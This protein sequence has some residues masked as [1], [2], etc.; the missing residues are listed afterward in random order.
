LEALEDRC[1]PAHWAVT[2]PADNINQPGTLRWA[3]AQATNG[4]TID[5]QTT[6]PI[7]LAY[8]EL[9]LA[10]DVTIDF[11]PSSPANQATV[12]GGNLSRVFEVAPTA[13]VN[14]DNLN[15]INGAGWAGNPSG[16]FNADGHGGAILNQGTLAL[17]SCTLAHNVRLRDYPDPVDEGGA[18]YNNGKPGEF[19]TPNP[20]GS[21]TLAYCQVLANSARL[22][23]GGIYNDHGSVYVFKSTLESNCVTEYDGGGVYSLGGVLTLARSDIVLNSAPNGY[24][25]GVFTATDADTHGLGFSNI[26]L[27][28]LLFNSA[29]HDGGG[30]FSDGS[31]FLTYESIYEDNYAMDGGGIATTSGAMRVFYCAFV[32]NHA[33]VFGG[34][35][36]NGLAGTATVESSSLSYNVAA[37]GG[38][39]IYN[40]GVLNLGST[41]LQTNTPDNLNNQGTYNDLGGNTFI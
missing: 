3:V 30:V 32:S 6:Q 9:Y 28:T 27:C 20:V 35:I 37:A 15:I 34:A 21:L 8:E 18:I 17:T 39:G 33:T 31:S 5:I 19:G 12:S 7:V 13:H 24:G 40:A 22:G 4:D 36:F 29:K 2:S 16:T 10:H 14:L 38:G 25:G 1:V 41:F 11:T 26:L 23:G